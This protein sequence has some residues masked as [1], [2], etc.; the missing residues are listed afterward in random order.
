MGREIALSSP[1]Q[2]MRN[3]LSEHLGQDLSRVLPKSLTSE[4]LILTIVQAGE[5]NPTLFNCNPQ[6]MMLAAMSMGVLGL[7]CDGISGQ[8]YLL[9]FKQVI[10]PVTGY[11]GYNTLAARNGWTIMGT[12]VRDG[13]RF[14]YGLGTNPQLDH[15]P[16]DKN[17][18]AITHAWAVASRP[19]AAPIIEVLDIDQITSIKKRSPGAKRRDSPWNDQD[20]G[21]PAMASKS[22]KRRLARSVPMGYVQLGSTMADQWDMNKPAYIHSEPET[23]PAVVLHEEFTTEKHQA[24]PE[25]V[26]EGEIVQEWHVWSPRGLRAHG[27]ADA[28]AKDLVNLMG[29]NKGSAGMEQF[30]AENAE[31]MRRIADARPDLGEVIAAARPK[32]D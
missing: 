5:R 10:Q 14:E 3:N 23:G 6:S 15:R 7:E 4:R 12:V 31:L 21:F 8:G 18:G 30:L 24:P 9:P 2:Q 25:A 13:D 22:V 11:K 17:K 29:R 26:L 19:G 27:T 20:I 32:G 16:R 1:A 28:S